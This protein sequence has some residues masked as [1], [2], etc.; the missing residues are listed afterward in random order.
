LNGSKHGLLLLYKPPEMTSFEALHDIKK[1]LDIKKVGHAGTLDRFAEGL[2]IVLSGKMTKLAPFFTELPKTYTASIRFGKETDTLDP[3]GDVT[4]SSEVIPSRLEIEQV[5]PAFT[6][7]IKQRPPRYSAVH[8]DGKRAYERVRNGEEFQ[9]REREVT[10]SSLKLIAYRE[11]TATIETVCSRGTYIRSLARDIALAC[12]SAG[13]V[14]RLKRTQIGTYSADN[15]VLPDKFVPERDLTTG[16][17]IFHGLSGNIHTATID[18]RF[19]EAIRS[20]K[21]VTEEYFVSP[22]EG[23]G[24]YALFD[25]RG[26][27]VALVH[28]TKKDFIYKFVGVT[29]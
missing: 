20:G 7:R 2:L 12:G 17:A 11:Q 5:L 9:T 29:A 18:N 14:E 10:I 3:E 15:G 19:V 26:R 22:P 4:V 6:G 28:K 27:F 21:P 23:D 8:V 16:K 25:G 24:T 13:Y 1:K